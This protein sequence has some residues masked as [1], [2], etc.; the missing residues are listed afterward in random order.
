MARDN[1]DATAPLMDDQIAGAW[2]QL[3]GRIKEKW[4]D[5]TD[6]ELEACE[7]HREH[8]LGAIQERTGRERHEIEHDL[9][10][11]ATQSNWTW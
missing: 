8:V 10:A 1:D 11:L 6:D 9:D 7:G 5:L 4:G 3:K 2:H